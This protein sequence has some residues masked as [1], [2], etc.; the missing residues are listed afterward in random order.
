MPIDLLQHILSKSSTHPIRAYAPADELKQY[1]DTIFIVSCNDQTPSLAYNDGTPMLAFLPDKN[2]KVEIIHDGKCEIFQAGWFST[3][4]FH[5]MEIRFPSLVAYLVVIR[6]K[7]LGFYQL[8]NLDAKILNTRPLWDLPSVIS[9]TD[10]LLKALQEQQTIQQKIFILENYIKHLIPPTPTVDNRLLEET[11][12]HIQQQKGS[13]SIRQLTE[14]FG[15]NYKWL[16]RNFTH[17]VGIPPKTYANLQRFIHAYT[18]WMKG[19]QEAAD[20]AIH[21]GYCDTRHF[22]KDFKKFVGRTPCQYLSDTGR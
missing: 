12:C 10:T 16:E 22:S 1:V 4:S 7:V 20:I 11:I 8:W 9:S 3:R 17:A 19:E 18:Q 21:N 15:L 13:V 6:F 14:K 5:R 2:K